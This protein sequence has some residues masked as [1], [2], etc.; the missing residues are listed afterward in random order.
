MLSK[1]K[2]K[3]LQSLKHKKFRQ[4]YKIFLVEG[5]KIIDTMLNQ[6]TYKI[7]QIYATQNW[8]DNY[9]K[10]LI[11]NVTTICAYS[12]LK[13][14]SEH[15]SPPEV[16]A[17]IAI[18]EYVKS[19]L[20]R[21]IY[22]DDVQDPG[23]VGTIIRIADWFGFKSVI[24]SEGSA[25]FYNPKV[26]QSTMGSFANLTLSTMSQEDLINSLGETKIIAADMNGIPLKDSTTPAQFLLAVGNEGKGLS[27]EIMN[28]AE[29]IVSIEGAD[30]R[31]AESLNV[32]AATAIIAHKLLGSK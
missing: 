27:E 32:S 6:N 2:I 20:Q 25:D 1:S 30:Q 8:Y 13:K 15:R 4:K 21:A 28:N 26:L 10:P 14:L 24:R 22:L 9:G 7:D 18:P 16:S 23:N 29:I 3:L 11:E 5:H 17:T 19:E 31:I 12:Q